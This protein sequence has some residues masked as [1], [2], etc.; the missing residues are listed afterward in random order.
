MA[1]NVN[2]YDAD[3]IYINSK[4]YENVSKCI[5]GTWNTIKD[6]LRLWYNENIRGSGK[7][8]EKKVGKAVEEDKYKSIAMLNQLLENYSDGD[9]RIYNV[10]LYV[11]HIT[12]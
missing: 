5:G 2:K 10:Q 12:K 3:K 8:K 4:S 11:E 1:E 6:C 7:N 9:G